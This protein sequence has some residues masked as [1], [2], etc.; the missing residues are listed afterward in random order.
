MGE[1]LSNKT[2]AILLGISVIL[3]LGGVVVFMSRSGDQLTGAALTPT[4]LARINISS[5]ASINWTVN[6]VDWGTGFVNDTAQ[7]CILDTEG[8]NN[9]SNCS[10]FTTVTEG[11]RLENDGN[12][13]VQ[14]NISSNVTPDQFIGGTDPWFQWKMAENETDSCGNSTSGGF[15]ST[16]DGLNYNGTWYTVNTTSTELCPCFDPRNTNDLINTELR[17]KVPSDS[18]TGVREA[19]LTA[20]ATA[21]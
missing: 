1:D 20:V 9:P 5:R 2:L 17:V 3:S 18:F 7:F 8:E 11:L 19:T 12:R 13:R 6:L 16:N 10:G 14:V 15:C 4:A 21:I